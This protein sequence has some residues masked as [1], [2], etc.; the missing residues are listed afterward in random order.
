MRK[1]WLKPSHKLKGNLKF[2]YF[3]GPGTALSPFQDPSCV[4]DVA[5]VVG[6]QVAPGQHRRHGRYH[7]VDGLSPVTKETSRQKR[8]SNVTCIETFQR[9]RLPPFRVE[10]KVCKLTAFGLFFEVLGHCFEYCW[11]PGK[12]KHEEKSLYSG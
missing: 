1:E 12:V 4:E 8:L 10:P 6:H 2:T 7:G 11:G 5:R 9:A 3:R